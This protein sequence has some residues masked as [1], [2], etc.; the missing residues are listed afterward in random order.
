MIG[1]VDAELLARGRWHRRR[2]FEDLGAALSCDSQARARVQTD[3][4]IDVVT[5]YEATTVGEEEEQRD[6]FR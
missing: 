1:N 5:G 3:G 2:G 6:G 4:E